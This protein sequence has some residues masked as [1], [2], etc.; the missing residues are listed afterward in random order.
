MVIPWESLFYILTLIKYTPVNNG[1][2]V[3]YV[4]MLHLSAGQ[5]AWASASGAS[6][7]VHSESNPFDVD[8][9]KNW[10]IRR[11]ENTFN[12][13][14]RRFDE[15][16]EELD[17][18]IDRIL[19]MRQ[20]QHLN[21]ASARNGG[22]M[23]GPT[24]RIFSIPPVDC[25]W[26]PITLA[27]LGRMYVRV[28][29]DQAGNV[30]LN[31]N[32][33]SD[34]ADQKRNEQQQHQSSQEEQ[35]QMQMQWKRQKLQPT[36]HQAAASSRRH[37]LSADFQELLHQA[38]S[39]NNCRQSYH[40]T[41]SMNNMEIDP[42]E[43]MIIDQDDLS[44]SDSSDQCG[45]L[46]SSKYRPR[47]YI[48]LLS[49]DGSNR[50]LLTWMK[51]WDTCVFNNKPTLHQVERK[52]LLTRKKQQQLLFP[53]TS[54]DGSKPELDSLKRPLYK[55]A[56]LWGSP[57]I[58]KTTLAH[59]IAKHCG[60]YVHE[61]NASDDRSLDA[62]SKH[63]E[64]SLLMTRTL[65]S[66]PKPHCVVI[67]EIDGAPLPSVNYLVSLVKG[68]A[69]GKKSRKI[70]I[71]RPIVCICNDLF[72]PS[73]RELRKIALVIHVPSVETA[74]LSSR[75]LQICSEEMLNAD[76]SALDLL[77]QK[78]ENDIRS[79]INTLQFLKSKT[80]HIRYDD[81]QRLPVGQKDLK[82]SL[83]SVW[84][85]IFQQPRFKRR[86]QNSNNAADNE[87]REEM[88]FES[89]L[90]TIS[91]CENEDRLFD[92]LFENFLSVPFRDTWMRSV[93]NGLQWLQFTDILKRCINENMLFELSAYLPYAAVAFH[94]LFSSNATTKLQYPQSDREAVRCL[95][96]NAN[97]LR[98][99]YSE[100]SAKIHSNLDP[101]TLVLNILPFLL[102][103]IQPEIKSTNPQLYSSNEIALIE[104][105]V[106]V[107]LEY[108]ATYRQQKNEDGNYDFVLDPPLD[109]IV[110][111]CSLDTFRPK[112]SYSVKQ[113]IAHKIQMLKLCSGEVRD[114]KTENNKQHT[115]ESTNSD[116]M[117]WK[118]PYLFRNCA[119][120]EKRT[121]QQSQF[122][123]WPFK[124]AYKYHEVVVFLNS[125][126][127]QLQC[128]Q[129]FS[130]VGAVFEFFELVKTNSTL[131]EKKFI[132]I[133][134]PNHEATASEHFY[135][136]VVNAKL[137]P[138]IKELMALSN[139]EIARRYCLKHPEVDHTVLLQIMK[140]SSKYYRWAGAD[141]I[142]TVN[143]H[144][145]E[146]MAVIEMNSCPSGNKSVP[147]L[148]W[149]YQ[150]Y[151][152]VMQ[153]AFLPFLNHA[154]LPDGGCLAV[155][156]DVEK[157][158]KESYAYAMMLAQL[159]N[160]TVYLVNVGF[161]PNLPPYM[162]WTADGVCE[163]EIS[164]GQWAVVRALF[165]YVTRKPWLKL[166]LISKTLVMNPVIACVA[167]GR[168]KLVAAKAY[169]RFN[170]LHQASGLKIHVPYT[171]T[172]V[173]LEGIQEYAV[174]MNH[175]LVVKVPYSNCG[176]GVFTI[177]CEDELQRFMETA[178]TYDKYIVQGIISHPAWR[179][180]GCP[181]Q[182]FHVGCR[183]SFDPNN[184]YVADL[185]FM[186]CA[187]PSGW[188]PVAIYCRR[189]AEPLT[190]HC[191]PG[192]SWD[193]LGTNL[194]TG[195]DGTCGTDT[196][197][198]ILVDDRHFGDMQLGLDELIECYVQT[199]LAA[200]AVDAQCQRLL[201][202]PSRFDLSLFL[203]LDNDKSFIS[204]VARGCSRI[205]D[206]VDPNSNNGNNSGCL[207]DDSSSSSES[208]CTGG[209]KTVMLR[210]KV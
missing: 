122:Q 186:V 191:P 159:T 121:L 175:Q 43:I 3:K 98:D 133:I 158:R 6:V 206:C 22:T 102:W 104:N 85:E 39:I 28:G 147:F 65:D 149:G 32:N 114:Q 34:S 79:C 132:E 40:D 20:N 169:Q 56:L 88:R 62:F 168:N 117:N 161:E 64:N 90:R 157:Q 19:E 188:M 93:C 193:I 110:Q 38:E 171:V 196:S 105:A 71:R 116:D 61:M 9:P 86:R 26:I 120:A 1:L 185:R 210:S 58:G 205:C 204:E 101:D 208:N 189:A 138:V 82:K 128:G 151:R 30:V 29:D 192:R 129:F 77:C 67:D 27:N 172:D 44:K 164:N 7:N 198:L 160:E 96:R 113:T 55:I 194:S 155:L 78:A 92:G 130:P 148:D 176:V 89:I 187:G 203:E 72:A 143:L 119:F 167:G 135:P 177:T 70:I 112:L 182:L 174:K 207:N 134:E 48:D 201:P 127:G 75:L 111:F 83:F 156:Y 10:Y 87:K 15:Q 200:S 202:E 54:G 163:L 100:T 180:S 5:C 46:W 107:M 123:T 66:N 124:I 41:R 80:D 50:A 18:A 37:L 11:D 63:L 76:Q 45:Q 137:H 69:S 74:R 108:N 170:E 152:R 16:D 165:R 33:I 59:V 94:F 199:V 197:R 183:P 142:R 181:N 14:R 144:G 146:R 139:E 166:P 8:D 103:I 60:Y 153:N 68:V 150:G 12:N 209:G 106:N 136:E 53:S 73:L 126:R 162:R 141:L 184:R 118:N 47:T 125:L 21:I 99:I 81:I 24:A 23:E 145:E 154:D 52:K 49:D 95:S 91:Q 173:T 4:T 190:A 51:L 140:T 97:I 17:M 36:L 131:I 84:R 178:H 109:E 25:D 2:L 35:Q 57:G 115:T 195:A 179:K 31:T 42:A 13:K